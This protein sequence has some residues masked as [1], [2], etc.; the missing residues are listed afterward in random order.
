[1]KKF[2]IGVLSTLFIVSISLAD[3]DI[4]HKQRVKNLSSGCCVWCSLENLG[5]LHKI[6]ELNGI[7]K[8]RHDNYREVKTWVDGGFVL[9]PWGRMIQTEGYYLVENKAPGTPSRV[10]EEMKRLKVKH[11]VQDHW[12]YDTDILKE[13]MDNNLGCAIGVKDYPTLG[14]YHMVTLTHWDDKKVRFVD[15]NGGCDKYEATR[16][17]FDQHWTGFTV[18]VYPK[19]KK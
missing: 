4:P 9:D 12:T 11:K 18:I 2:L 7:T 5:N 8:Y 17:W 19:E 3:I 1:M 16:E 15:N 10:R 13:A 6:T 14:G